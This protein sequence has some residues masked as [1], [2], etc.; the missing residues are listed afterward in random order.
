[1]ARQYH[2]VT[3]LDGAVEDYA[4]RLPDLLKSGRVVPVQRV[5]RML[6]A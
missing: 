5:A 1:M 2:D 3:N 6:R 4:H